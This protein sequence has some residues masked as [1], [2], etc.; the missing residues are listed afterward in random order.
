MSL[1][2]FVV[3]AMIAAGL[4]LGGFLWGQ[5]YEQDQ[6]PHCTEDEVYAPRSY[7]VNE[8]SDLYCLHIDAVWSGGTR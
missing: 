3:G 6:L 2:H 8:T 1:H 5:N 4:I 7:P